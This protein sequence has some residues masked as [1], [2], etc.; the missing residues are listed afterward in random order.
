MKS[1]R[2]VKEE[3]ALSGAEIIAALN[4]AA[5]HLP[6]GARIPPDAQVSVEVPGDWV[7]DPR[8]GEHIPVTE[9]T[10]VRIRWTHK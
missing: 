8:P 9:D 7:G 1:T 3:L 5:L 2:E 4:M 10:P 6:G